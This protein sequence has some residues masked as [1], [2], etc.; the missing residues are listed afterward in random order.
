MVIATKCCVSNDSVNS[1]DAAIVI[2]IVRQQITLLDLV[3]PDPFGLERLENLCEANG[4]EVIKGL[5]S[6]NALDRKSTRLNSSHIP[7]SRMPSSA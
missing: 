2:L 6:L 3:L 4:M 1:S 7:L 5:N